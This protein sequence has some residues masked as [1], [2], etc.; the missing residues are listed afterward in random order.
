[1]SGAM[2]WVRRAYKVPAKR[3]GRV[4]YSGDGTPELGTIKSASGGRLNIKLDGV[5]H[6]MPFHPTWRLKYLP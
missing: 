6:V 4:E 5:K 1:M 2:E 3:G